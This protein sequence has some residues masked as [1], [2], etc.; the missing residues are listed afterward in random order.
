MGTGVTGK[1]EA[2]GHPSAQEL[3]TAG[4]CS[5]WQTARAVGSQQ[6]VQGWQRTGPPFP[7]PEADS[8]TGHR[9]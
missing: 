7:L 9:N 3:S 1:V 8:Q 6:W 2:P 4:S 5:H